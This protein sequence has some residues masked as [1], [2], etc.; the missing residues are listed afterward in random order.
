MESSADYAKD[1]D[2]HRFITVAD[3]WL[4]LICFG[5]GTAGLLIIKAALTNQ[6]L[7]TIFLLLVMGG[8]LAY[9]FYSRRFDQQTSDGIYY[10]GFLFTLESVAFALFQSRHEPNYVDEVIA[11]FGIALFTTIVGLMSRVVIAQMRETPDDIAE[12]TRQDLTTVATRLT[13]EL[14]HVSD[15]FRH[16]EQNVSEQIQRTGHGIDESLAQLKISLGEGIAELR[17]GLTKSGNLISKGADQIQH[18]TEKAA[19]AI[20]TFAANTHEFGVALQTSGEMMRHFN[21]QLTE[22]ASLQ[23]VL[24]EIFARAEQIAQATE[25][26]SINL[27]D[28]LKKTGTIQSEIA[29][30][31]EHIKRYRQSIERDAEKAQQ[32]QSQLLDAMVGLA[33]EMTRRLGG[34]PA[35]NR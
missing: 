18:S 1:K 25:K 9:V 7:A 30:Q 14:R 13:Q 24:N 15:I 34:P 8:Y 20:G 31:M 2:R 3:K 17:S 33:D 21:A 26:S 35:R 27:M 5:V 32:A 6:W 29:E 12:R 16:L 4:F 23:K 22:V 11:N 28:L 10:L 19:V